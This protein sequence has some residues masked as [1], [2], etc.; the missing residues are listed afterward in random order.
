MLLAIDT[1]G[2]FA[3]VALGDDSKL[4]LK[5]IAQRD[6]SSDQSHSEELDVLIRELLRDNN[7]E[8]GQI[9]A[10]VL[11]KGPGSFTGLRIG[12]ALVQGLALV[13]KTPVYLVASALGAGVATVLAPAGKGLVFETTCY[14][15]DPKSDPK[16]AQAVVKP[17]ASIESSVVE[18]ALALAPIVEFPNLRLA[19]GLAAGI[20]QVFFDH[21]GSFMPTYD[22]GKLEPDY[23]R[24]VAAK[25]IA[26]RA[27]QTR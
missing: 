11:G 15:A 2:S 13:S 3:S 19:R 4:K 24:E 17:S 6:G 18:A 8:F 20:L 26:E 25:S 21:K 23:V 16:M 27:G 14:P 7:C 12:F 22:L 9:S 5:I 1:S 10:I